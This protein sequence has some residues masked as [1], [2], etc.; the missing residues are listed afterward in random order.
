MRFRSTVGERAR[1]G[2]LAR[3]STAG[4]RAR[5]SNLARSSI[6]VA[7][8]SVMFAGAAQAQG[9][10]AHTSCTG[11]TADACQ[12]AVDFFGYMAPQ[13]GTAM[14]GGNTTLAQGGNLGGFRFGLMP[15]FAVGVRVN[16]VM[17]DVPDYNPTSGDPL[18][19]PDNNDPPPAAQNL[20]TNKQFVALPSIDAAIGV[21]GGIPLA[22]SNVGGVDVLLSASYVPKVESD[23]FSI[24]P[25]KSL[26]FGYGLRVGILQESLV[27]PGVGIS[28][29]QRKFPVT[30][31][32]AVEGSSSV[33]VQDLDL[34]ST[35][36][37]LTVSKSLLLFGLAAGVGQD[38]YKAS[39][40]VAATVDVP[41]I[42]SQTATVPNLS[43][44]VTRTNYFADVS[45]NLFVL[46][47][48]GSAGMVSGGDIF[49]FNNFDQ[50]PDK[51]RL[52]GSVGIRVGL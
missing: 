22:L 38:R 39:T 20:T 19:D 1:R 3:S 21:F 51:S 48:V 18:S 23:D 14:T 10:Q 36:W 33:E 40:G 8:A 4:E 28:F 50:A 41:T 34:K 2:N 25:D 37:R 5:R 43:S 17:G 24:L 16:A 52:Y 30:T 29:L 32:R 47:L 42:G 46:K 49:T 6:A 31:L 7:L 27:V 15:R 26:A 12:Q 35:A 45:M 9:A 44:N 11:F 13:L